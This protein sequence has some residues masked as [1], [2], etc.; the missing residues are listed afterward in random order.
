LGEGTKTIALLAEKYADI[1][2]LEENPDYYYDWGST[3]QFS[4][5]NKGP[6]ECSAGLFDMIDVDL[7]T[8]QSSLETLNS[9]T[10]L[11]RANELLHTIVFSASRMLLVTR[12]AE[13]KTTAETFDLFIE[14][15]INEGYISKEFSALVEA[16]KADSKHD[17]SKDKEVVNALAQAVIKLYESMDDSLQFKVKAEPAA[18]KKAEVI[19]VKDLRGVTCPFNF[20]KTKIEL[21][22]LK[23][24]D[25]LE[26]WLDDGHPIEN[27]PGSV[28]NEGH[29]VVSATP[30]QDY[31]KVLI[32]KA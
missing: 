8:I 1:P 7:K 28:R 17:F 2:S 16:A 4:V 5:V 10:D 3:E 18:E 9:E 21:S 6:A 14:K 22:T 12:G 11:Q 15:F 27:V 30:I 24:G 19:R 29:E 26:I 23:S 20:V 32:R 25:L 13:A 31:W